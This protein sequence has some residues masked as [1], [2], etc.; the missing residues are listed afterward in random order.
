MKLV[1]VD[2]A[3]K[4][5]ASCIRQEEVLYSSIDRSNELFGDGTD[6]KEGDEE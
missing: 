2:G 3:H 4:T 6:I 1:V 5:T